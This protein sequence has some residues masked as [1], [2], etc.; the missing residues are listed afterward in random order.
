MSKEGTTLIFIFVEFDGEDQSKYLACF[1]DMRMRSV[2]G[3]GQTQKKYR[4]FYE[5]CSKRTLA[6]AIV[7]LNKKNSL[8]GILFTNDDSVW[9][10]FRKNDESPLPLPDER[11]LYHLNNDRMARSTENIACVVGIAGIQKDDKMKTLGATLNLNGETAGEKIG[12][13]LFKN[14]QDRSKTGLLVASR[15]DK[16][17]LSLEFVYVCTC[18]EAGVFSKCVHTGGENKL[19]V[20]E[21]I[22]S[23][24]ETIG[25]GQDL[26]KRELL[27][28][29]SEDM[30][31]DNY[32]QVKREDFLNFM[33]KLYE[34]TLTVKDPPTGPDFQCTLL[35]EDGARTEKVNFYVE[36][37]KKIR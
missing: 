19:F 15:N 32:L 6:D 22:N 23:W 31:R 2:A 11:K 20:R 7:R 21:Q 18:V 33:K 5:K 3:V 10:R 1:G 28:E 37:N 36:N 26:A 35:G 25:S 24:F 4:S 12:H 9:Q 13:Y 14:D 8:I 34:E 27:K 16:N 17:K 30:V 29:Y